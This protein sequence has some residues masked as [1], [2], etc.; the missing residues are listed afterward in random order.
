MTATERVT[1]DYISHSAFICETSQRILIFDVGKVPPR[2]PALEPDWT[3]LLNGSKPVFVLSSHNHADH[4]DAGLHRMYDAHDNVRFITGDFGR[5]DQ[6][7]VR[8]NPGD[9]C[10]VDDC[11]IFAVQAT[12]KG[13][14]ALM[15]FPEINIYY[16]GDHA[17]WDDLPEFQKPF[18]TS[19]TKLSQAGIRPDLAFMPVG[20]SD[21]W[22]EDALIDGCRLAITKLLPAGIIPMHAFGYE[23][24]YVDFAEKVA[25][26][27]IP[28]APLRQSGD[29]F[30]FADGHFTA[31]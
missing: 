29:R 24:F 31:L 30:V 18:R 4:Y 7:T 13:I 15:E 3:T 22:Q 11:R 28:V 21:G 23:S 25:D 27:G 2:P 5:T 17:I 14:A 10:M 16:G 19:M 8:I 1:L 12:D 20:T 6:R 9:D 26:L